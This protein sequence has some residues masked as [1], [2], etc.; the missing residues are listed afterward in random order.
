ML[1]LNLE[2]KHLSKL[3]GTI[4]YTG[5]SKVFDCIRTLHSVQSYPLDMAKLSIRII[6]HF[7]SISLEFQVGG[8]LSWHKSWMEGVAFL[9]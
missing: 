3:K 4:Q 6:S 5:N 7:I 2:I 8:Y 9:S 1:G